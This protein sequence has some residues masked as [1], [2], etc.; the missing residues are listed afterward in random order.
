MN[1]KLPSSAD[2]CA[3]ADK[4]MTSCTPSSQSIAQPVARAA[5]TS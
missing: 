3:T 4:S 2:K 5:I 1:G